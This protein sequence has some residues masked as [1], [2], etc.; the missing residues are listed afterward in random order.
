VLDLLEAAAK[1][2]QPFDL[3]LLDWEIPGTDTD[4]LL[5]WILAAPRLATLHVV[6]M[7]APGRFPKRSL[8]HSSRLACV[9]KP[10]R[11]EDLR[12]ALAPRTEKPP[13][14]G[15]THPPTPAP[16]AIPPD[17]AARGTRVLVAED[18]AINQK[19]ACLQLRKLGYVPEVAANGAEA[20][21]MFQSGDF[22]F[23]LMDCQM[24]VMDGFEATRQIRAVKDRGR[25]VKIIAMTANAMQGDRE[26]CLAAGM[27]GYVAKP[28]VLENLRTAIE[29]CGR[30]DAAVA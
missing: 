7:A 16:A 17:H 20:V 6:I 27:D 22:G 3:L 23:I 13:A 12:R 4:Q 15:A 28:V 11:L 30:P 18:N 1:A 9:A 14:I 19:V 10:L 24:P 29:Q 26:R 2:G 8:L 25:R 5:R 21:Q